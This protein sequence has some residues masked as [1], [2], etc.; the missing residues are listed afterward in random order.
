MSNNV[1]M[2]VQIDINDTSINSMEYFELFE[3]FKY[4][5]LF[6]PEL[7]AIWPLKNPSKLFGLKNLYKGIDMY[8]NGH[9]NKIKL[10][11][12]LLIGNDVKSDDIVMLWVDW[13]NDASNDESFEINSHENKVCFFD[14]R[15]EY[16][17]N[18]IDKSCVNDIVKLIENDCDKDSFGEIFI[19]LMQYG[20]LCNGIINKMFKYKQ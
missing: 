12:K 4:Y 3:M 18:F 8:C 17:K 16:Y 19:A 5:Q 10:N 11:A 20:I 13:N 14:E 7:Y 9:K 2:S 15:V 6:E 1:S